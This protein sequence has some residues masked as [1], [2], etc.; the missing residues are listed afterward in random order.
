MENHLRVSQIINLILGLLLIIGISLTV[1]AILQVKSMDAEA[2]GKGKYIRGSITLDNP[3][4]TV[5]QIVNFSVSTTK[6]NERDLGYLWVANRCKQNGVPMYQE[7][8]GVKNGLSGPF[9]LNWTNGAAAECTAYVWFFPDTE[10]ALSGM[11]VDYS[12]SAQ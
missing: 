2:A 11:R 5:G 6:A 3:N 7:Y 10:T 8:H 4:P 1:Y 9:N 12:V